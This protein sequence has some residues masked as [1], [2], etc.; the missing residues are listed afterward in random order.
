[1]IQALGTGILDE[2]DISKLQYHKIVIMC[3]ADVDGSHIRTLIL[4]FF[5][6]Q[7]PELI[8]QGRV[9]VAQ[10]PLYKIT[11]KGTRPKKPA[12][13]GA[14][15]EGADDE[16]EEVEETTKAKKGTKKKE[17]YITNDAE[18]DRI[19]LEQGLDGVRLELRGDDGKP[20]KTLK[21]A[22]VKRLV[23]LAS[24]MNKLSEEIRKHGLDF[25]KFL[26]KRNK[27]GLLPLARVH[28]RGTKQA[29]PVFTEAELDQVIQQVRADNKRI[30]MHTD[31]LADREGADVEITR[32]TSKG[33]LEQAL[34]E[35]EKLGLKSELLFPRGKEEQEAEGF[36]PRF[37]AQRERDRE[38]MT[39]DGLRELPG[40]VKKLGERGIQV[41]RYKG[42][43]EMDADELKDTTMDP[44]K[45]TLL[46]VTLEDMAEANR[47]F[48]IL[49]G[50]KVEPRKEYIETHAGEAKNLDV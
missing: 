5:F 4:T 15:D 14:D 6:R 39:F 8:R 34:R 43:G 50:T 11:Y 16:A 3:D 20:T 17:L 48:N 1:M 31:P 21:T 36:E 38:P 47:I 28:F 10:P 9:Y 22:E 41:Q 32:F 37:A 49:M 12:S 25:A 46:R 26:S 29:P 44:E 23:E 18:F 40:M 7:M 30:W 42:L 45:R 24:D 35:L 2:F 13:E 33:R 27:D 19:M